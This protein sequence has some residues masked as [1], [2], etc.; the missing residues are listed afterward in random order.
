MNLVI[1]NIVVQGFQECQVA[2]K[3]HME[4]FVSTEI[5]DYCYDDGRSSDGTARRR[6]SV[7]IATSKRNLATW[8]R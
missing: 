5:Q 6:P 7:V 2:L 4:R 1:D 8:V 3:I